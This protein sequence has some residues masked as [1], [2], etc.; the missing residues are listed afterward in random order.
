MVDGDRNYENAPAKRAQLFCRCAAALNGLAQAVLGAF[1][2][3][4]TLGLSSH[5]HLVG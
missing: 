1:P 3:V 2:L 5:A 4:D